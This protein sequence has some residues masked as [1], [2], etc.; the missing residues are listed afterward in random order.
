MNGLVNSELEAVRHLDRTIEKE[1]D[2]IPVVLKDGE[3]Q[4][5][6]LPWPTGS[7]LRG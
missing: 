7:G 4:A 3:V 1:S 5:G 6:G 2:V